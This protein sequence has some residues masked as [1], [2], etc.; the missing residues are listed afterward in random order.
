M[1]QQ[2]AVSN[3]I[4]Q[5]G[6]KRFFAQ[7]QIAQTH[8]DRRLLEPPVDGEILSGDEG[9]RL[10]RGIHVLGGA[11][12]SKACQSLL[13]LLRLPSSDLHDLLGN[14]VIENRC[15]R[16]RYRRAVRI[17]GRQ[18]DGRVHPWSIEDKPA[19]DGDRAWQ[20]GC[21]RSACVIWCRWLTRPSAKTAFQR[22]GSIAVSSMRILHA[23]NVR[24]M[25]STGSRRST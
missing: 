20:A 7:V 21:K 14:A 6:K 15:V 4:F 18:L 9:L 11:P 24:P 3:G 12:D 8:S 13:R 22:S 1:K 23:A 2:L 17:D 19:E 16:W 25:T 10:F 5:V